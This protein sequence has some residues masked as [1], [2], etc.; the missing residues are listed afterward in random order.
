M[1]ESS[2]NQSKAKA[3][4]TQTSGGQIS[5][6]PAPSVA[7]LEAKERRRKQKREAFQRRKQQAKAARQAQ[8]AAAAAA[9]AAVSSSSAGAPAAGN[10][11]SIT[12]SSTPTGPSSRPNSRGPTP[13]SSSRAVLSHMVAEDSPPSGYAT[14]ATLASNRSFLRRRLSSEASMLL[15]SSTPIPPPSPFEKEVLQA[16]EAQAELKILKECYERHAGEV[17]FRDTRVLQPQ[18]PPPPPPCGR[19]P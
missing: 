6:N 10:F 14:A 12:P 11:S 5:T 17:R 9:A 2:L 3:A 7:A 15:N 16:F 4:P 19:M 8:A 18:P 1:G 13:A